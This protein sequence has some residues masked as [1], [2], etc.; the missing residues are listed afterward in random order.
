VVSGPMLILHRFMSPATS[1]LISMVATYCPRQ[2]LEPFDH[3][4]KATFICCVPPFVDIQRSGR[5]KVG[6]GKMAGLRWMLR[7]WIET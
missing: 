2:A 6:E 4:I 5:N 1:N 7:D 3:I